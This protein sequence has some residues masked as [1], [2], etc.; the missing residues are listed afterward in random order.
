MQIIN[1]GIQYYLL[2]SILVVLV[3]CSGASTEATILPDIQVTQP[4]NNTTTTSSEL[5]I[6]NPEPA[7]LATRVEAVYFH[8]SQRCGACRC[9]EEQ[10]EF[11]ILHYF[12]KELANGTLV[13]DKCDLSDRKKAPLFRKY[14]AFGS[15]LF[16]N[17][18]INN[19]NNFRNVIEIWD[20]QCDQDPEGFNSQVRNLI[21]TCLSKVKAIP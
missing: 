8:P 1:R 17:I 12:E 3:S 9:L 11:T 16:V 18:V 21:E 14:D 5:P 7:I 19:T 4:S 20:W 15:Q 10:I 2:P 13:F 6:L